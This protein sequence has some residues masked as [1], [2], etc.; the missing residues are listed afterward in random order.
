[1]GVWNYVLDIIPKNKAIITKLEHTGQYKECS[2]LG[3]VPNTDNVMTSVPRKAYSKIKHI[4]AIAV[5]L[6]QFPN[7][8]LKVLVK[9]V[10][11]INRFNEC[12]YV[13]SLKY[14]VLNGYIKTSITYKEEGV[15]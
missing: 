1:M 13:T 3:T 6:L 2:R 10:H 7:F 15:K 11:F 12:I 9:C 14:I 4:I 8:L 5:P